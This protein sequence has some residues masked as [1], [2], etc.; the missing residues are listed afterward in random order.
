MGCVFGFHKGIHTSYDLRVPW[1]L[2]C[3]YHFQLLELLEGTMAKNE[4]VT[5]SQ[6][7]GHSKPPT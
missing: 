4:P 5:G 7:E 2:E 1:A 3:F 6:G